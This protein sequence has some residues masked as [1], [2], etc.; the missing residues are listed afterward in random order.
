[1]S[2]CKYVGPINYSHLKH[3]RLDGNN[4]TQASMPIESVNCLREASEILFNENS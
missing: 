1:M 4:L 2:F 3:L